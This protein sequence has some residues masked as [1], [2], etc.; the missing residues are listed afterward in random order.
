M[1]MLNVCFVSFVLFPSL[2]L[3]A[4]LSDNF[5]TGARPCIWALTKNQP[6]YSMVDSNG[7]V[8][9]SKPAGGTLSFQSIQL[10]YIGLIQGNFDASIAF[11][12]A[13]INRSGSGTNQIQL[14]VQFGGQYYAVVRDDATGLGHNYHV[15]VD[16]P[17][18]VLAVTPTTA[19]SGILRI[20]RVG[21][22]ITAYFNNT[23]IH[24]AN[25]NSGPVTGLWFSLQNNFT[26]DATA[27]TFD[28]FQLTADSIY[29]PPCF[30]DDF[31]SGVDP[32]AWDLVSNQPLYTMDDSNGDVRFAKPTGGTSSFQ[33]ISLDFLGTIQGDFDISVDFRNASINRVNGSPANQV[34]LNAQFGGQLFAIVRDDDVGFGDNYHVFVDPPVQWR[35]P[36][37]NTSTSGTLR[38]RR[39]GTTVTGYF[40][41]VVIHSGS[42]N[43]A[44]ITRL[45]ISLQN[46]GTTDATA[47][48]FDNVSLSASVIT[49]AVCPP[50]T[51][52]GTVSGDCPDSTIALLG[53]LVDAYEVGSGDLAGSDTT[54]ADGSY[55]I[56]DLP[57]GDYVVTVVTPLGYTT[58]S[59]EVPVTV[60]P[61]GKVTA[62][63]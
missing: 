19:T 59:P 5:A 14:N 55:G 41:G 47:V 61:G 1:R 40:N 10:T 29:S 51:I 56:A 46:N 36:V 8:R 28:D 57:I 11:R 16:P 7:D 4:T 44:D 52:A 35:G 54:G 15:Y 6:L 43:S 18:A 26:T 60:L 27:V 25:Y 12:N 22:T 63:I 58:P 45:W 48:T 31:D 49:P 13:S 50:G 53:V 17:S 42:Y 3:G 21:T 9:F 62:D 20:K 30:E 37:A 33:A 39:R 38:I 24:S 34:Q 2:S 32:C 23:V